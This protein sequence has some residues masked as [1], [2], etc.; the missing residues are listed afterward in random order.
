M[1][2]L[3]DEIEEDLEPVPPI[4]SAYGPEESGDLSDV[5]GKKPEESGHSKPTGK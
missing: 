2:E 4:G 3:L 5:V 1:D